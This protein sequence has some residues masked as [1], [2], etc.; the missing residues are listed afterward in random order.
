MLR[1]AVLISIMWQAAASTGGS[2]HFRP[3][4]GHYYI[5]LPESMKWNDADTFARKFK[6]TIDG[7]VLDKWHLPL[8]QRS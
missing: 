2:I 1:L 3:E 7:V 5:W 4:T 6:A 8:C